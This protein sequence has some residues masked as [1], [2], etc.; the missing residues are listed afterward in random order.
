VSEAKKRESGRGLRPEAAAL[1]PLLEQLLPKVS[2][3]GQEMIGRE[4]RRG[5]LPPIQGRPV[6]LLQVADEVLQVEGQAAV[7][8]IL[9]VAKRVVPPSS[10]DHCWPRPV[11]IEDAV[12]SSRMLAARLF[13]SHPRSDA[14]PLSVAVVIPVTLG[15]SSSPLRA[16][17]SQPRLA[18]PPHDPG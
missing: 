7:A 14:W 9:G 15:T 16:C 6:A 18:V 11:G 4:R 8:K 5:E 2:D 13:G 10:R 1:D 12:A 17:C 3:L